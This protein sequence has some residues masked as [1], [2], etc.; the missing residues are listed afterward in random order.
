MSPAL[1][2]VDHEAGRSK[3]NYPMRKI[4]QNLTLTIISLLLVSSVVEGFLRYGAYLDD[5]KILSEKI[6]SNRSL[7]GGEMAMLKDIIKLSD[8][9]DVIYELKPK[10]RVH[11]MTPY[12]N[13]ITGI[14]DELLSY[15]LRTNSDGIRC[16]W[17]D[18]IEHTEK[19]D[20][21]VV[22]ILGIGDS[23]L[24][25]A[26]IKYEETYLSGLKQ[27]L[28][29]SFLDIEWD[30]IN[31]GVP[32]Y[33]TAMEVAYLKGK[34]LKYNPAIV[35]VGYC[36]NDY[37]MP[38]FIRNTQDYYTLKKSYLVDYIAQRLGIIKRKIK[39]RSELRKGNMSIDNPEKAPPE[40]K[41]MVGWEG[42]EN[43]MRL[44]KKLSNK[45]NFEVVVVFFTSYFKNQSDR[46]KKAKNL[47]KEL[48]FHIIDI[49][50]LIDNYM[51]ENNIKQYRGSKLSISHNDR[52]PS[53]FL[54][55]MISK[56]IY[57]QLIDQGIIEDVLRTNK[58]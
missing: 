56:A 45:N 35:I 7:K 34:G 58:L 27:R 51:A 53:P 14:T 31:M 43:S 44:L 55:D 25:G 12:F 1:C 28:S 8:N 24:Y 41:H 32:G 46:D 16:S 47:S 3:E 2:S 36:T 48:G 10:I 22:R 42:Y 15:P 49:D 38:N 9:N 11:H 13:P 40:Y 30:I 6:L 52:H 50:P 33:N 54:H 19:N 17:K 39:S 29:E 37:N 57:R 21:D 23:I 20:I 4:I 18:C 26:W 5:K